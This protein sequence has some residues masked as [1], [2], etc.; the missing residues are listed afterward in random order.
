MTIFLDN[1]LPSVASL[2]RR[3]K[4]GALLVLALLA[5][6]VSAAEPLPA[7]AVYQHGYVYTVDAQDSVQQALAVRQG[8][9]VYVGGD[10]GVK[11]FIGKNTHS[12]RSSRPHAD[13]GTR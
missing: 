10:T 3:V 1:R 5:T 12:Y 2:A 6:G 4:G 9:I 13:A 11:P 7:D 8:T